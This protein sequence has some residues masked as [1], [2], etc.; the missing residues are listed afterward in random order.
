MSKITF[1]EKD[2]RTLQKNPNVKNVSTLAITYTDDFKRK[3]IEAYLAGKLPR[4]IFEENGFDVN[5][6]G[7]MRIEQSACRWK[8]AYTTDGIIG[9]TDNRKVAS[10]RPLKREL[11]TEEI[12]ER[13]QAKIKLL[14][15]QV[16]LLKS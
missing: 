12:I 9:L 5:I 2:I 6:L 15:A 11:S 16:S 7:I 8:K 10:G 4:R 3:F 1:S 13:Q 14:E